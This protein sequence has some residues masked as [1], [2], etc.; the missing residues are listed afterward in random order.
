M[1]H[2]LFNIFFPSKK[3]RTFFFHKNIEETKMTSHKYANYYNVTLTNK[4]L[5]FQVYFFKFR[6]E[7]KNYG[8]SLAYSHN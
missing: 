4:L 3:I 6:F 8:V 5:H 7:H 2:F 1:Q